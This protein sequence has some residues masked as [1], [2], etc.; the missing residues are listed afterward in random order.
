MPP[1]YGPPSTPTKRLPAASEPPTGI[2]E[3]WP[4]PAAVKSPGAAF[5]MAPSTVSPILCT[6]TMR[7]L[8]PAGNSEFTRV[9][10]G[11][12]TETGR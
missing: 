7:A 2:T 1:R 4:Q 8:T 5:A 12:V 6:V 11:S 3:V 9:P 10:D